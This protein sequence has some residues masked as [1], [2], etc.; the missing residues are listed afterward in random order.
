MRVF[1][2]LQTLKDY[3]KEYMQGFTEKVGKEAKDQNYIKTD[4]FVIQKY[5]ERPMLISERKFDIRT[6]VLV[7]H[8]Y[9]LYFFEEGY[10]RM[11][12]EKFD[13]S[14][15]SINN[16]LIHLTNNAV[17]KHGTN[18]CKFESGN[19]LSFPVLEKYMK[20][21]YDSAIGQLPCDGTRTSPLTQLITGMSSS[22]GTSNEK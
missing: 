16:P 5:I 2:E 13:S 3:L 15:G 14:T 18:Y 7:D 17:Q 1:S 19:Q 11:S 21:H 12:S 22:K 8:L 9:N 4:A 20:E 6:W 10:V